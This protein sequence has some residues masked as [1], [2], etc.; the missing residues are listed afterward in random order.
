MATT[1]TLASLY[2][3]PGTPRVDKLSESVI[4]V[5]REALFCHLSHIKGWNKVVHEQFFDWIEFA[6]VLPLFLVFRSNK[7]KI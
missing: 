1:K 4:G 3:P 2:W 6:R 5:F 7:Y